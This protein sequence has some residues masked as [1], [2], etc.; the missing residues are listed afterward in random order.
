MAEQATSSETATRATSRALLWP[1]RQVT[2]GA[3]QGDHVPR[4][5]TAATRRLLTA[6]AAAGLVVLTSLATPLPTHAAWQANDRTLSS[7]STWRTARTTGVWVFGD[8]ITASDS[9]E[10]SVLLRP[11]GLLVAVDATP[12]IPTEPAVDR[13][14]DRLRHS[15]APRRLVVALGTNDSDATVV[16]TQIGRVMGSVPSTTRVYWVN[17][18]KHRWLNAGTGSDRSAALAINAAIQ[19]ADV[20]HRNLQ[21]VDWWTTVEADPHRY[22]RDG[23]HTL[24]AGRA[25]RNDL[26]AAALSH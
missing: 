20:R 13:L 7:E 15:G 21:T 19:R 14:L 5:S 3:S 2:V 16:S 24:P 18:W 6:V 22:L 25:A 23:V 4:R 10:L 17:V 11:S 26:I 9:P 1:R 8:S 12:G